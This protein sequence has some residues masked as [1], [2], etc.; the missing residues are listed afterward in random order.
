[1]LS[2]SNLDVIDVLRVYKLSKIDVTFIVPTATGIEKSIMDATQEIRSFLK[3]NKI[4]DYEK[5]Q[6]GEKTFIKTFLLSRDLIIKTKTS[7]YRPETKDGDP[8]IWIY[9]LKKNSKPNDLLAISIIK[10]ELVILNCS[11]SDFKKV[12]DKDNKK[13]A[14]FFHFGIKTINENAKELLFKLN[15][16]SAKGFI[17]TLRPGDTGVGYTG[18]TLLGIRANSSKAPDYKGI[19]IKFGR[20]RSTKSGRTTMFSKVPDWNI[21]RIKGKSKELLFLR[22]KYNEEKKRMQLFHEISAIKTN[23]YNLRLQMDEE[24]QLLHQ[25]FI[26]NNF[27]TKDVTWQFSILEDCLKEKHKETFWVYADSHGRSGDVNEM[28]HY[29]KVMHTTG[30][31]DTS[32]FKI[33]IENGIITLDYTIKEVRN[34]AAKDKGYLFKI[35]PKNLEL[36]FDKEE[37]YTLG[38]T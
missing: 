21:S 25:V 11:Q 6:I 24:K 37:E 31:L 5:Q 32:A 8:R 26:E 18:E 36:L 22:G 38:T 7:L 2:S 10:S 35:H 1:M 9:D 33:L 27:I 12:L 23:S 15:E 4:H 16:I 20:K 14:S 3:N 30:K 34:K 13:Y 19:E 29:Q 17:K 28:F